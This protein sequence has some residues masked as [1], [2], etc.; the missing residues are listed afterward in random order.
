MREYLM[1]VTYICVC[2]SKKHYNPLQSKVY[3]KV[4]SLIYTL[5]FENGF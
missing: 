3:T 4:T 1:I 5:I 2:Q